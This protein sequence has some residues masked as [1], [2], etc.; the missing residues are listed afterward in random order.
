VQQLELNVIDQHDGS[1]TT[2]DSVLKSAAPVTLS[3]A[4]NAL[5]GHKTVALKLVNADL[6][7]L[8][9]D[10]ITLAVDAAQ[11][12]CPSGSVAV[13]APAMKTIVGEGRATGH[14]VVT[15]SRDALRAGNSKAPARCVAAL[16]ATGP[17]IDPS[18][19]NN[20]TRLVIDVKDKNDY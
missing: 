17:G 6:G 11:S 14:V 1:S 9:G 8:T 4:K 2:H 16:T 19:S 15:V 10:T 12:D 7:E 18:P 3:I 13:S 20:S 5:S